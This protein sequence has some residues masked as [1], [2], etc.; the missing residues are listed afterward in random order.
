MSSLMMCQRYDGGQLLKHVHAVGAEDIIGG[1]RCNSRAED[2][3]ITIFQ[4]SSF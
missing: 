2:P 1:R 4:L 3:D